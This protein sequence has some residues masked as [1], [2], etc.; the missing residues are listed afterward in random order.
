MSEWITNLTYKVENEAAKVGLVY[1][2]ACG[3][4]RDVIQKEI[5]LAN[6]TE[7]DHILCIGGGICPFSA[8]LFH[9]LTGAR[10]TVIDNNEACIPKA[11]QALNR[12]GIGEYVQVFCQD[13]RSK[14]ILFAEYSII[15]LALQVNPIER[16]FCTV[17]EQM[18]PGAKMLIRRP[19][20]QLDGMYDQLCGDLLACC[21]YTVHKSRNIGTTVLYTKPAEARQC[22]IPPRVIA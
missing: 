13:G 22:L 4:Y 10:V 21:P 15:H 7:K 14:D 5:I 20:E 11:R 3:Y 6:I 2:F 12:L 9:Q 8:I 18:M 16:V 19:K 17:E 1:K